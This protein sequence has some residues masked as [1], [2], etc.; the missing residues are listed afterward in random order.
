MLP[1]SFFCSQINELI[2]LVTKKIILLKNLHLWNDFFYTQ[3]AMNCRIRIRDEKSGS[4]SAALQS[5]YSQNTYIQICSTYSQYTN[6]FIPHTLSIWVDSSRVFGEYAQLNSV[7]RFLLFCIFSVYVQ[8]R[9]MYSQYTNRFIPR[10]LSIHT[11]SFFVFG[12]CTQI[13]SN[14]WN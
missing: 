12:K 5:T 9:S 4:G 7:L 3:G 14:I 11:D 1:H 6:R 10:I 2:L 8:I 13:I